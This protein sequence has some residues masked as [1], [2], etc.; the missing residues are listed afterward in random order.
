MHKWLTGIGSFLVLGS[1]FG[2]A[3]AQDTPQTIIERAIRAHGG[4]ER[5]ARNRSD[6]VKIK[7]VVLAAGKSVSFEGELSVQLPAQFKNVMRLT[8]DGRTHTLVQVLN[9]TKASFTVDGLPQ[10]L[11][12]AAL[13][14]LRAMFYLNR[15]VRLVPLLR[16]R[17]YALTALAETKINDRPA[18]GVKVGA[19]GA[20]E[21][22]MYFDKTSNLLIKT[23]HVLTDKKT[24]KEVWQEEL[25][26]DFRDLGGFRR[27]VKV[28]VYRNGMRVME[29]VLTDVKYLDKIDDTEFAVP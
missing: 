17:N 24:G 2:S 20:R 21:L 4:Q 27:P 22:R 10:K 11:D 9:G 5:L 16:D 28:T 13:T 7:G 23:E 14:E 26:S 6:K 8:V 3:A 25:Y 29:S 18:V 12:D 15:A 1:C 19:R